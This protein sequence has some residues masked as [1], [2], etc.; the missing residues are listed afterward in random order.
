MMATEMSAAI[1]PYG[2]RTGFSLMKRPL[3]LPQFPQ[4]QIRPEFIGFVTAD[5]AQGMGSA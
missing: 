3:F 4:A 1:R 5:T 2:G